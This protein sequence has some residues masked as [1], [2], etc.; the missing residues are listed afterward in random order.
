M[1]FQPSFEFLDAH[2]NLF[3]VPKVTQTAFFHICC[4]ANSDMMHVSDGNRRD[5]HHPA[6]GVQ[7]STEGVFSPTAP[8]AALFD[9]MG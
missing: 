7:T 6:A 9:A 8:G 2:P 3:Y 4:I 5:V 1:C